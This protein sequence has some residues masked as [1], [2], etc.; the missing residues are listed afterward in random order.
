MNVVMANASLAASVDQSEVRFLVEKNADGIIVVDHDGAVL[1]VNPA[2]EEIFG[3]PSS[4]LIGSPVGIP[5]VLGETSQITVH[6]PGGNHVDVEIR[7][8]DTRWGDRPAWLASLRD[9]SVRV[10]LEEHRR[11]SSKMEAIGRLTAGIAHDFNNLLTVVLGN[12]EQALRHNQDSALGRPL[13]NAIHG[14]RRAAL[15]TERLL[16]FSRRKPLE[17]KAL[18]VNGLVEGMSDLLQ[19]T[20]GEGV[21]IRTSLDPDLWTVE[22]DP[23]ELEAAL[24]NLAVNARDAMP[25]GGCVLIETANVDLDAAY[26]A[27]EGEIAAGSYVL[28]SIADTGGG[29]HPEV[30]KQVFEPFFTTKSDG[31]GTGLGLSQVYGFA[32]QSG[33]HAKIYSE[34][35]IGTTAK[36]Y[37]PKSAAANAV[38]L[39]Q[40]GGS[41]ELPLGRSG[42][43]VLVVEDDEDVRNYTVSSLS[44]LG[45]TVLEAADAQS[46]LDIIQDHESV[47]LLF[48]DLG[49][50]GGMD[51]KALALRAQQVR[52]SLKVLLTTAYAGSALVHDGRLDP[53][54]ELLSKPFT[55]DSLARRIRELL[56]RNDRTQQQSKILIVEDE[57][58]LRM[59][60][61]EVLTDHGWQTIE[62]G[63]FSEGAEILQTAGDELSAAIVD[64][65]L[66]DRSGDQ[67]VLEIRARYPD[68]PILLTTGF[69][70]ENMRARFARDS[71]TRFFGK[72]FQPEALIEALRSF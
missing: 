56:D 22:V 35:G 5:L 34:I 36:I 39:E 4:T 64:L 16:S 71:R 43:T 48:T 7:A 68:L 25:E 45:Y 41:T 46:A 2:A 65:G 24:L 17:P 54:T 62:A 6:R 67:L 60:V 37:L 50:P 3:R 15:L 63:S 9:I 23:P 26:A 58:L 21:K 38:A 30:L 33:G 53:G 31:R 40:S 72:P 42:E 57:V 66:P 44:E 8:V 49:L 1:F 61:V 28:V 14:A 11:H 51:G 20:L 52:N 69:A 47:Q 19:R 27:I 55:F 12:L 59:L 70:D 29:I 10:A 32:K 18:N 13:E